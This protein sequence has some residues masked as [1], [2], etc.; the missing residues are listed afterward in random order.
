[1]LNGIGRALKSSYIIILL[2][3]LTNFILSTISFN[4]F[5]P[6]SSEHFGDPL[7]ALYSIF[8]IFTV[9]GWYEIPEEI[10]SKF[11]FVQSWLV[12]LY[13]IS[14]LFIGGIFG[15]SIVNSL[16]VEG[17]INNEEDDKRFDD[18]IER[19]DRIEKN[20]KN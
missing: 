11:G 4:L 6:V 12:K 17:M 3:F 7:T 15:L 16:F 13:F 20:H 18:I 10:A 1:M 9:E 8:K 2:F 14:I 5:K 19:L